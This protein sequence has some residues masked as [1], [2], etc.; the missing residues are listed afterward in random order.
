MPIRPSGL[1][2]GLVTAW[3]AGL[4]LCVGVKAA[5]QP[6]SSTA[7]PRTAD[8]K[9]D[10]SGIWQA[11]GTANWDLEAHGPRPSPVIALGAVGAVPPGVSYVGG[12]TIPYQPWAAAKKQ[13]NAK[14][15]MTLDPEVKCY[16]PGIPRATYQGFPFQ[17]VQSANTLSNLLKIASPPPLP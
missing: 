8:G 12:G 3:L 2:S 7:F 16:M 17:I 5:G 1:R 13:E 11:V 9:P 4:A 15:W 10:L 14:N 6:S